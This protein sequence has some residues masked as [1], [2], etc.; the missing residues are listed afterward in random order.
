MCDSIFAMPSASDSSGGVAAYLLIA[1]V[2][3]AP[4]RAPTH[5]VATYPVVPS[6]CHSGIVILLSFAAAKPK[7]R[8]LLM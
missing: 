6:G 2:N 8:K 5:P 1:P 4:Y 7:W 3:R